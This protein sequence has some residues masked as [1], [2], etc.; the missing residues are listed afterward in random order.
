M[1]KL[2]VL[3]FAMVFIAACSSPK[4][5]TDKSVLAKVN[6][7]TITK[8]N[9]LDKL[10]RL[11][12]WARGRFQTEEGKKELLDE[13]IKEEL[14]FQEAE[15]QGLHKDK[16]YMNKVDEFRRM[17][18]ISSLLKREIEDKTQLSEEELKDFYDK[19]PDEF[20]QGLQVKAKHILVD[21]EKEAKEIQEKLQ[22]GGDFAELAK[23]HSKDKGSAVN[24]GDLGFFTKGRMVPKFEHV[25]FNLKPGELSDPVKTQFGYHLIQVTEKKEGTLRAFEEVKASIERRLKMERQRETFD[26]YIEKLKGDGKKVNINEEELKSVVI[27]SAP[28]DST[29]EGH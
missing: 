27:E 11:P 13:I 23:A 14:L 17:T 28:V 26:T 3:I 24:G 16:E 9:F 8:E 2:L 12:E 21:T 7:T 19:H 29:P 6:N 20:N 22:K 1:R 18:L 10:D 25:A 4:Q 15:K 5:S